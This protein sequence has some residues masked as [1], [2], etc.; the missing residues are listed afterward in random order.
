[1]VSARVAWCS[2]VA[3]AFA[4]ATLLGQQQQ[5]APRGKFAGWVQDGAGKRVA[6]ADVMLLSR[7]LPAR[8]DLGVA[9]EL[10]V[11][12]GAD[13]MF[14]TELLHGRSYT[15]WATWRDG[16][17]VERRTHAFDGA[18][19][20]PPQ[21]LA[22]GPQ[23]Q[24]RAVRVTG[25]AAWQTHAPLQLAVF[26]TTE[27]VHTMALPLD[28]ELVAKVPTLPGD[29][30]SF[31]VRG[32][33]GFVLGMRMSAPLTDPQQT[34]VTIALPPPRELRVVVIDDKGAPIAGA[35]VR[36]AFGMHYR[37]DIFSEVGRTD[38]SGVVRAS[39]PE[40][41][42]IGA[43]PN[44][45]CVVLVEATGKQRTLLHVDFGKL[46]GEVKITLQPGNELRGRVLAKDGAPVPGLTL[47]PDCYAMIEGGGIGVPQ[48]AMSADTRGAFAFASLHPKYDFR[49]LA[50]L[51]ASTAIAAGMKLRDGIAL[52][53]VVWLATG[54]P[55][56]ASPHDLGD[57]RLDEVVVA[58]VEV[59]TDAGEPVP[60]AR[61]TVTTEDLYNSPLEY[62]CDRVGRLQFPLPR[63]EI[64]IGAWQKG[65][66]VTTCLVRVPVEAND[67]SIAPLVL[68]L[69]ATRTVHGTVVDEKGKP[70][71]GAVVIQWNR[72][73]CADRALA[74][75]TFLCRAES[76]PT[77]PDGAFTLTL[78]LA[79]AA[80]DVRAF[81][82]L[83]DKPFNSEA[84]ALAPDDRDADRLRLTVAP[85]QPDKAK[86]KEK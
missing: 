1:M 33:G 31:E 25:A 76:E 13:G 49:L 21:G 72:A 80:F 67:P 51:D 24:L 34:E 44:T 68:K 81:V 83:G 35:L 19:P 61:L 20:G 4:A 47:L 53:P 69:S 43:L 41:N 6:G 9:D 32:A 84:V 50:L 3:V 55:P 70:V 58:Q 18:I 10:R 86:D 30:V 29:Y 75:L 8:P 73:K 23:Q 77:G 39:V 64:R 45:S 40:T 56:F 26:T 63:G 71:T 2:V 66:G 54:R 16:A 12:T 60:G 22:E 82:R 79:D 57:L 52:A 14:R 85:W 59:K 5:Q 38:A 36:H 65:G 28:A 17:G 27:N 62:V 7:P 48:P 74:N 37:G 42:P 15:C 46:V 78:P 11:Q